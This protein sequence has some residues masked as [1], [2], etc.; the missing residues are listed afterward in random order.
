MT[1]RTIIGILFVMAGAWKLVNMWGIIE[2]DWL[3]R[4]PWTTYVAPVL[5]LYVGATTIIDSYRCDPDQWLRRPLPIG[6]DGKRICCSVHYGGDEYV[7][8]GEA[9]HGARLDAFC[10]GIRMDLR[11]AVI[12]ED[13]EIDVHTF[14]GGIELFVPTTVNVEVKSQS[15]IGGVGNHAT[16]NADPKA[17]TIHIVASNFLGGVDIKN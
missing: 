15:F 6:E 3:W 9:F 4:Q 11:E 13:E 12:T 1:R 16:R 14:C 2:N 8:R 17:P 7:Y 10:G 5:L